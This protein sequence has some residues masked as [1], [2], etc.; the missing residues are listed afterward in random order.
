MPQA[1]PSGRGAEMTRHHL[2]VHRPVARATSAGPVR[3]SD[4][5]LALLSVVL[6]GGLAMTAALVLTFGPGT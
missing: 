6:L 4:L 5:I 3:L 2:R 1:R